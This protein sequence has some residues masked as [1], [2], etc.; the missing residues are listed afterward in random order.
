MYDFASADMAAVSDSTGGGRLWSG[1]RADD[2]RM[3]DHDI[4][5]V[6]IMESDVDWDMRIK[7]AMYGLTGG[8]RAIADWPFVDHALTPYEGQFVD[9]PVATPHSPYGDNWD[10]LWLGH[11][12]AN[13]GEDP[14]Y[15]MY[16]D[17][18]A[19]ERRRAWTYDAPVSRIW[20]WKE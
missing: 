5:S 6:L 17:P 7:A 4:S 19:G 10:I 16:H 12:G 18:S 13:G 14:R 1:E 2:F 3:L 20:G 11:C 9:P 8:V 15:Y